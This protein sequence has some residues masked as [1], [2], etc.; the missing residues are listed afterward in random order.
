M[1]YFSVHIYRRQ[2]TLVLELKKKGPLYIKLMYVDVAKAKSIYAS[3]MMHHVTALF[4][5]FPGERDWLAA[6]TWCLRSA[7]RKS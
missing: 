3:N 5:V 1:N 6:V 4:F 2:R 7:V